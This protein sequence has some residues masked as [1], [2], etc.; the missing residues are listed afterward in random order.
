MVF[1]LLGVPEEAAVLMLSTI[2]DMKFFLRMG[3]VD[4]KV[5]AGSANGK[6]TQGLCQND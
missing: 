4:S 2:Q 6:K 5:Y 1:Q 3:F